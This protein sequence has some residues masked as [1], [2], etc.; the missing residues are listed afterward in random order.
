MTTKHMPP[1][2]EELKDDTTILFMLTMMYLTMDPRKAG[3]AA[4]LLQAARGNDRRWMRGL[5]WDCAGIL[6]P[7]YYRDLSSITFEI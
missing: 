4:P 3:L 1:T 6:D 2:P 7:D 5:P